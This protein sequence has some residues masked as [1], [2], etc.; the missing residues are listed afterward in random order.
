MFVNEM[1]TEYCLLFNF[2]SFIDIIHKMRKS[3]LIFLSVFIP[4][5]FCFAQQPDQLLRQW[6]EKNSIEKVW[7]HFDR[8]NYLAGE[9]AWFKAYLYADYQPDSI[10]TTLYAELLNNKG[11]LLDRKV[12][13]ILD[14]RTFGQFELSDSLSSGNYLIRAYT[15]STLNAAPGQ[16]SAYFFQR[17]IFVF[18][19][20]SNT[21]VIKKSSYFSRIEFFPESG[22]FVNGMMNTV[23]FKATD[24]EGNPISING[25]VKNDKDEIVS[26]FSSVHDGMGM[27]DV[28]PIAGIKYYAI[29]KDDIQAREFPL[30]TV[31]DEGIVLRILQTGKKKFYEIE[32]QSNQESLRVAYMVGQMQNHVVFRNNF[33]TELNN[34]V[35]NGPL[36]VSHLSSG[37]LQITIFNK[38]NIPLAERLCF[39]N[40]GEYKI[41]A[42]IVSDTLSFEERSRNVLRIAFKDTV[43]GSFSMSVVD[44]TYSNYASRPE[45]IYSSLLLTSDLH[46][47]IHNPAY[48]FLNDDDS[49]QMNLDL[50]MMTNGWRRFKWTELSK[51]ITAS[52]VYNDPGYIRVA[53][54][55]NIMYL[56][57][58]FV[59]KP[60]LVFIN[61]QDHNKSMRMGLTD[62]QG[63]FQL[64]SLMFFGNALMS[65][66][67]IRG[68]K[69]SKLEIKLSGDTLTRN[70]SLPKFSQE[71]RTIG[72][73]PSTES[74]IN[75]EDDLDAINKAK[76]IMLNNVTVKV[77]KKSAEELLD[78]KYSKGMFSGFAERTIDL[79]HTDEP[80]FQSNIFDYLMGRVP[81]LNISNDGPEYSIHYRQTATTS[82]MGLIPMILYLD[83]VQTDASFIS[84]IPANDIAMVKVFSNFVGAE[85]NGAGGVLAIYTKK[86]EDALN[87][88][89]TK[90]RIRYQGYSVIKEFYAPDYR[91]NKQTDLDV[92]NRITLLW[93]PDI[94]VRGINS[95]IDI[96][97][98][99][100][101]RSKQFKVV[102]EGLTVDGKMLM[103]EKIF[104]KK[105]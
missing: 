50:V 43:V 4:I 27:F 73:Q 79:V 61:T 104:G 66:K 101:D 35:I 67:D 58:M 31:S 48:Y 37:I 76:G 95:Q 38:D 99:N 22:N 44:P 14:G 13:P 92:D 15:P 41:K 81:G 82:S 65:F 2:V 23:A 6:A 105:E 85:G 25:I 16:D 42:N 87:S 33:S 8:D 7:L 39:V 47:Y 12:L 90:D 51:G 89:S 55:V 40:N 1:K 91:V 70:F 57:K 103:L 62:A 59:S 53:G 34:G 10:S 21:Q 93:R 36:D 32:Q 20:N 64:D 80:I 100:N 24:E 11:V 69:S 56:K 83:E 17:N 60:F 88:I 98:Y 78:E 52:P 49:T 45:N 19:K 68:K 94:Q 46:G 71:L 3:V 72:W 18:G 29:V 26:E 96:P 75:L 84:A 54:K 74:K 102:L 77:K 97:F 86:G 5:S 63:N 9:T 30:P 28:T